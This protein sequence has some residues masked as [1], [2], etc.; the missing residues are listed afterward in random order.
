MPATGPQPAEVT[1]CFEGQPGKYGQD[2]IST[3]GY[4]IQGIDQ[5]NISSCAGLKPASGYDGQTHSFLVRNPNYKQSTDPTRKNYVDQVRVP[6]STR[7]TRTST[8]RSRPA[9]STSRRRA[10]RRRS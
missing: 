10:S 9:S 3:A 5:V 8:T 1:K 4:M 2:L 6:R 7:A